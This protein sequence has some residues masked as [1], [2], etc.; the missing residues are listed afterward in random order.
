MFDLNKASEFSLILYFYSVKI[1]HEKIVK[2]LN[3]QIEFQRSKL[4]DQQN[5]LDD[6][7]NLQKSESNKITKGFG[8]SV[9]N[10]REQ[11]ALK[12]EQR[13][14]LVSALAGIRRDMVKIAE[15]NLTAMNEEDQQNL[16]VQALITNKTAQLQEK[17]DDYEEQIQNLKRELKTQKNLAQQYMDEAV[18]A[19]KKLGKIS[20]SI[21][22]DIK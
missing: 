8:M 3:Y 15:G 21:C 14:E 10:L 16:S 4:Q 19:R 7:E 17:I 9:T 6:A 2:D 12:E 11:L 5:K 20:L 1:T 13:R 18:D 22:S